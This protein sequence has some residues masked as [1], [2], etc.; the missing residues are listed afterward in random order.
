MTGVVKLRLQKSLSFCSKSISFEL[1]TP[2]SL[3]VRPSGSNL[4]LFFLRQEYPLPEVRMPA[5]SSFPKVCSDST[6]FGSGG[7][8]RGSPVYLRVF[9]LK[10]SVY[11]C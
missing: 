7:W 6:D 3:S 9:V 2:C 1:C 4:F 10:G 5:F 8:V 11:V